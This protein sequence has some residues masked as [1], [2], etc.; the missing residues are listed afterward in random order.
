MDAIAAAEE[1]IVSERLRQKLNEVN[2]AAQTQ[3][4]GIQ[5]H[6]AF[7]LQVLQFLLTC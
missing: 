2:V 7:T 3:L 1:R 6:I 5:D 4:A